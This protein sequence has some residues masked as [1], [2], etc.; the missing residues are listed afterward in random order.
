MQI[1]TGILAD[2]LGPRRILLVG[3]LLAAAGSLLFAQA[4]TLDAALAGRTLIG[5][6]VSVT[7][8]CMLKLIATEFDERRFATLVG[9]SMLLGN[10][11][12]VLAGAPL[13]WL[14]QTI[15]WRTVFIGTA[16][17]SALI[18]VISWLLVPQ[19]AS[20]LHAKFDRTVVLGGLIGVLKNR[21]TWPTVL[22]NL[23]IT[24]SFF[25]FAGLW[26]A[27]F[28]MNTQAMSRAT[29]A[30]H[31]SLYFL[32]FALGCL[33]MGTL[34]D[35]LGRRKPVVMVGALLYCALWALLLS[36]LRFPP[37]LSY[38]LLGLMGIATSSFTLGWAC[39]KEVNPPQ[40]SGMSTSVCNIGGFLGAAILQPLVGWVLDARWQGTMANGVRVYSADDYRLSLTLLGGAALLGTVSSFFITETRCRNIWQANSGRDS[41]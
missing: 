36:G 21:A 14:A 24:G 18:G 20:T 4:A 32:G 5:F 1:P 8:I 22:L 9:V 35:R 28:L 15:G 38:P 10:L 3:G 11:G 2:T 41:L 25:S 34:S 16:A 40:L 39:A 26:A 6:G 23:G 13:S 12:S 17:L 27:P 31:L 37:A 19:R 29:A 33:L 30:S 7:F